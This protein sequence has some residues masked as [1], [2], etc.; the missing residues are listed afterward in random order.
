MESYS[1][2]YSIYDDINKGVDYPAFA[3]FYERCF[4]KYMNIRPEL[5]LDL[6]CGTGAM[7]EELDR[8]GYDMTGVD[9]SF[10]MLCVAKDRAYDSGRQDNILYLCQSMTEFELYGTVDACVCT[11]DGIN[12]LTEDGDLKKTL[13]CVHN[14]LIPNGIFVFDI[15]SEYKFKNVYA[16]N[17]FLYN[18]EVEGYKYF[19]AWQ[20]MYDSESKICEFSLT[21]FTETDKKTYLRADEVQYQ[22]MYDVDEVKNMLL[23]CG[24]EIC[25]ICGSGG[26]TLTETDERI[27]FVARCK[28]DMLIIPETGGSND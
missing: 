11:L 18:G 1:A 27:F 9:L 19:C 12:Y 15:S 25:E 21:A 4:E 13:D 5:V 23:D 10:D 28:K 3:D 16:N 24:F 6:A 22:R 26:A 2:I 8:R 20:N 14:Y 7:T 17:S